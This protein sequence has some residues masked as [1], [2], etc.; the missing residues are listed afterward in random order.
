MAV[1]TGAVLTGGAAGATR[2][3][4]ICA[5]LGL[6]S[7]AVIRADGILREVADDQG[8]PECVLYTKK[9]RAYISIFAP[10]VAPAVKKSWA[11]GI[12]YKTAPLAGLSPDAVC[13]YTPGYAVEA[14]AFTHGGRFVWMTT[15]GRFMHGTML[16]LAGSIYSKT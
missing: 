4:N 3:A 13:L 2:H 5:S 12:Q 11:Y 7:A 16:A 9:G 10:S 1:L 8:S 6:T 15:A 14:V